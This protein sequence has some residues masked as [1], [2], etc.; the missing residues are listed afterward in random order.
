MA[1][2]DRKRKWRN[3]AD[4]KKMDKEGQEDRLAT[5]E[6]KRM[7]NTNLSTLMIPRTE[8]TR[9]ANMLVNVE[10]IVSS[11]PTYAKAQEIYKYIVDLL[12]V[13]AN[14]KNVVAPSVGGAENAA[15]LDDD[16]LKA[17]LPKQFE[18]DTIKQILDLME[19]LALNIVKEYNP[20]AVAF[21][22]KKPELNPSVKFTSDAR[23]NEKA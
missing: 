6:Q 15:D 10:T 22:Q 14:E 9:V 23:G 20:D 8:I 16:M 17:R 11:D 18:Y 21:L 1:E 5:E 19:T 3:E 13:A 2:S 7:Y 12:V 4:F